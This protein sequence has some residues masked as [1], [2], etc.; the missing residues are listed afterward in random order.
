MNEIV[1][2]GA[3]RSG[4]NML[5]DILTSLDGICT[6]PC[7]EINYIW[8]HEIW[9]ILPIF[10]IPATKVTT[11]IKKFINS[12]FDDIRDQYK[13]DIVVEKTCA[14]SLRVP[15]VDKV[16]ARCKVYFYIS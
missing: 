4:T 16:S 11:S 13:S 10:E 8:R 15:F 2:I 5:R 3:P 6:W 1:I 14:N 12:C 9:Y 7:D